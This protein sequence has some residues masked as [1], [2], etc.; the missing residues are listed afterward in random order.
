MKF[1]EVKLKSS[2]GSF[3]SLCTPVCACMCRHSGGGCW[4]EKICVLK[5]SL[6]EY[7][8]TL[9]II[10]LSFIKSVVSV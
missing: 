4:E 5:I 1:F 2:C 10:L 6:K 8:V 9:L 3:I 7:R